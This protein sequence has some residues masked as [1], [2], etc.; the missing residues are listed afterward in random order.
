MTS[1]RTACL[2]FSAAALFAASP[3]ASA[4][5][6]SRYTSN[7]PCREVNGSS[8]ADLEQGA[9]FVLYKCTGVAGWPVWTIFWEGTSARLGFGRK[10]N[11]S[12]MFAPGIAGKTPLEWRGVMKGGKFEP[13]AVILRARSPD[14]DDHRTTLVVYRL[15]PD[16]TSC[17][18]S[19]DAGSNAKA[20]EIAD[21]S[22]TSFKCEAEPDL[23]GG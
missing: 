6:T 16:G 11:V 10:P 21:A 18:I 4:E 22:L 14:P 1:S 15:R 9:D 8:K 20:R 23:L 2:L 17:I 12:G 19:D 5:P 3:A 7:G 13:F